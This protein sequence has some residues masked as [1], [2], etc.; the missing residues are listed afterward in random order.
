VCVCVC[1]YVCV[2]SV[3]ECGQHVLT[4]LWRRSRSR[5]SWSRR[6][7]PWGSSQHHGRLLRPATLS[8]LLLPP[9][10]ASQTLSTAREVRGKQQ[11]TT[12]LYAY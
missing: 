3:L 4:P 10:P 11:A 9:R 12:T 5:P 2:S 7:V 6:D 8:S 1:V